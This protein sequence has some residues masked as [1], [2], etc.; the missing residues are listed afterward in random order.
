MGTRTIY[1]D[2]AAVVSE[3][4]QETNYA[5][6]ETYRH[7][8]LKEHLLCKTTTKATDLAFNEISNAIINLYVSEWNTSYTTNYLE[9]ISSLRGSFDESTVTW[10]SLPRYD[11][12]PVFEFY[13]DLVPGYRASTPIELYNLRN[14]LLYGAMFSTVYATINTPNSAN[15]PYINLEYSDDI[16]GV[17]VVPTYP[18]GSATIS[19]AL[20]TV[21]SWS[22]PPQSVNT[23]EAVTATSM[24]FR[25]R[26]SGAATYTE[27]DVGTVKTYTLPAGT[28][29]NGTLEWQVE[30]VSNSGITT[31]SAWTSVEVAEPLS[32]AVIVSPKNTVLD[33]TSSNTF[34]WEHVISNGTPQTQFELQTSSDNEDW[35]TLQNV[36][37]SDTF[38]EIPANTLDGGDLY[39]RV[40]TYNSDGVAGEWSESVYCIVIAAPDAPIVSVVDSS[41]RFAVRWQQTGQQAY[42]LEID[43]KPVVRKFGVEANYRHIDYLIPGSHEIRIR[44]QNKYSLWSDWGGTE[45]TIENVEGAAILLA[46]NLENQVD[47][48]FRTDGTYSSYLIYRDGVKIGETSGTRFTDHYAVG[49]VSYQVRGIYADNGYYTLSNKVEVN[50]AVSQMMIA[51]VGN[52]QWLHLSLSSAS[53]RG[54]N[55]NTSRSVTYSNYVGAELPSAEMGEHVS[56]AFRFDVAWKTDDRKSI[57]AFESLTGKLVCIKT[58]YG[59]RIV[60]ILNNLS[61]LENRFVTTFS[62]EVTLV[63]WEEGVS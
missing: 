24:K 43:G 4:N 37:T 15:K 26:Y 34:R 59:R 55:F 60:G 63:H 53:L 61:C 6:G 11:D 18:I 62:A 28:L 46:V 29:E 7:A 23:L 1:F 3:V 12:G 36:S 27:V 2:K 39:W 58:P 5:A 10:A 50:A 47:L 30:A 14:F 56:K 38:A 52:P 13:E 19:K 21:F 33:G 49:T 51:E 41:P 16:I 48:L 35:T 31:T 9:H 25:W 22:T 32:T 54:T 20:D 44:I 17:D 8:S 57:E 42:E 40:R 45:I